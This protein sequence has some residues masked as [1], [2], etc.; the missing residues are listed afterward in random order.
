VK[1]SADFAVV[2]PSFLELVRLGVRRADDPVVRN[3]LDVV[4]RELGVDTPNGQFWHRFTDDGYGEDGAGGKW[5][6]TDPG[7][8]QTTGRAWPIFAGERGEYELLAGDGDPA[9]RLQAMADSANDGLMIAEQ[10]RDENAPSGQPGFATG[11]GHLLGHPTDVVARP[12][13]ASGVVRRCRPARGAARGGRLRV[14]G[15]GLLSTPTV[16]WGGQA[17]GDSACTADRASDSG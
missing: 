17:C 13:R 7:S 6:L 15:R 14:P 1:R 16:S 3:T 4:E 11:E 8:Q 5:R 2:D 10:V 9:A 12:A